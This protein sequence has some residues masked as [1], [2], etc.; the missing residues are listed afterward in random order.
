MELLD[1][2]LEMFGV[3][4]RILDH[5]AGWCCNEWK[6]GVGVYMDVGMMAMVEVIFLEKTIFT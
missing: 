2:H 5:V 1:Y 6:E 4:L 3:F